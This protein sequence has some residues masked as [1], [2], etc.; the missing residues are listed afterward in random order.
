M[1][2]V[3]VIALLALFSVLSILLS[4]EDGREP[5]DYASHLGLLVRYGMR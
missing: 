4:S 2:L 5:I 3:S 1:V